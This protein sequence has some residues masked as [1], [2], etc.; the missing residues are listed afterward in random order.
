MGIPRYRAGVLRSP[1]D[2]GRGRWPR[3]PDSGCTSSVAPR[4]LFCP[5]APRRTREGLGD[6]NRKAVR[7]LAR[8][9]RRHSIADR[10]PSRR[11]PRPVAGFACSGSGRWARVARRAERRGHGGWDCRPLPESG[12]ASREESRSN[13]RGFGVLAVWMWR[14]VRDGRAGVRGVPVCRGCRSQLLW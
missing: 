2:H 10:T 9:S 5:Q 7:I 8:Q 11:R 14:G 4:R 13:R 6:R 1:D 12:R 3:V